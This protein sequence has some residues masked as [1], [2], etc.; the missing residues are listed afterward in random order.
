MLTLIL[1]ILLVIL[2]IGTILVYFVVNPD[3]VESG[4]KPISMLMLSSIIGLLIPCV[5]LSASIDKVPARSVGIMVTPG[6]VNPD[7]YS[8]GWHLV[9]PWNDLKLMDKSEWVLTIANPVATKDGMLMTL[10]TNV[11]WKIDETKADWIYSNICGEDESG[12]N[13]NSKYKW[14]E[15]NIISKTVF[16]TL[17]M[18]IRKYSP[19]DVYSDKRSD[20]QDQVRAKLI[21]ELKKKNMILISFQIT[22]VSY[23][24]QYEEAL[25]SK[26]MAEQQALKLIEIT[27]QKEEE[28]K[29]AKI[30]KEIAIQL[31]EG[32]AKALQIKGS[33]I[34]S[35]PKIIQLQWIEKW[36][37]Q[38]P[39]HIIGGNTSNLMNIGQ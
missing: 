10:T 23:P 12:N 26:K 30:N 9:M 1:S 3:F 38:L 29:Q 16:S 7:E 13:E 15:D 24:K 34:S 4:K 22:A 20:I 18:E 36:D 33:S 17:N 8:T 5:F 37:G 14:I 19:I 2:V 32:E 35:N 25:L 6:G 28:L 31:A 27:K 39:T 21:S 11:S